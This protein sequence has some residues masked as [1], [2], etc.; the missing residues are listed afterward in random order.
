MTPVSHLPSV[1]DVT[2]TGMVLVDIYGCPA[3][4]EGARDQKKI[5]MHQKTN[6]IQGIKKKQK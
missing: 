6:I 4:I 5:K 1:F 2:V 3:G